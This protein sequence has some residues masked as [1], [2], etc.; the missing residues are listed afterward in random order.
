MTTEKQATKPR[1]AVAAYLERFGIENLRGFK[2]VGIDTTHRAR[3]L[4]GPNNAGKTSLLRI[5]D[6]AMNGADEAL[7]TGDR[8]LTDAE[9]RLLLPATETAGRARRITM[10][11]RISDL[12]VARGFKAKSGVAQ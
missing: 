2:K 9:A 7:L 12:R 5:L 1:P 4:V 3:F 8:G 11:I 6:W 10:D